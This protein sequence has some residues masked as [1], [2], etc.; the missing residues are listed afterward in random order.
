MGVSRSIFQDQPISDKV[1]DD[2]HGDAG[3]DSPDAQHIQQ[4]RRSGDPFLDGVEGECVRQTAAGTDGN[5]KRTD[6]IHGGIDYRRRNGIGD[7]NAGGGG[8]LVPLEN[9]GE[10]DGQNRMAHHKRRHP[11]E[12]P[13]GE[14]KGNLPGTAAQIDEAMIQMVPP[15]ATGSACPASSIEKTVQTDRNP[16]SGRS[17]LDSFIMR[18]HC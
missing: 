7:E 9:S 10:K 5:E 13:Q 6:P 4:F 15:P 11:D 12:N 17:N 1:A 3:D 8:Q 2:G 18:H 16:S 14:S